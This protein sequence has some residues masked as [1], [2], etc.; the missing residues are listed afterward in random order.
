MKYT[1]T[2]SAA[3]LLVAACAQT[4]A[5]NS[6]QISIQAPPVAAA[7]AFR[8]ADEHCSK[9]G[10]VASPSGTVYGTTTVFD[11]VKGNERRK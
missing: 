1:I 7:E 8:M 2:L 10:K 11:C 6:S 5:S 9:F 4:V 3:A